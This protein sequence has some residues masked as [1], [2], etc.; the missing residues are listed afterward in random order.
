MPVL[1]RTLATLPALALL[2]LPRAAAAQTEPSV[3]VRTWAPSMAPEAG[4]VLEPTASPGS[5][6]WNTSAWVSY[7]QDPVVLRSSPGNAVASRPLEHQLGLDLVAGV[8]L[9][10]RA[11]IGVDVPVLLLQDGT[12]G[13]A[14]NI[15]S[16]GRVPGSGLGDVAILGKGTL[17]RNDPHGVPVGFGLAALGAVTLPT[18][19]RA[20]F[21]G[22]GSATVALRL[23]AEYALGPAAVR[24]SLG[25][26]LRTAQQ[27]W[28][29]ASL[30]GVTF[31]DEIPWSIGATLRP[32]GVLPRLD[33][34]DR[35]SWEIACH[36][37][38]PATP[39]TV[40]Q[41]GAASLSPALLAASDRITFGHYGD[42]FVLVGADFGLDHAV[43]VP[44]FRGVVSAGWAPRAHDRDHDGIPDDH[45]ECPDL[46]EDRDGIQDEDGCPEDDAD[47]DGVLD[48]QDACPLVPGV[49]WNDP[50]KNG[51]PAP[52]TDGDGV[53][54]P[55][56]A[57]PAVKGV[58]SDDPKKNGCPA[59]KQD[60]DHDGIPDDAD[61]CP[62]EPEDMD[63]FE[64]FDGC[65]DLDDD[66]DGIPDKVDACPRER[67]EPS[68]DPTRNGCPSA[69]RD[70]DTY[71][72]EVDACPDQP[73]TFNGV[74][75]EDGCPD[76]GGRP[77]VVVNLEKGV[78]VVR[79]AQPIAFVGRKDTLAIDRRS[80]T[81]L[82]ALAQELNRRPD[83]TLAV[84][85]RPGP[86]TPEEAQRA[87]LER[88][89]LVANRI[90][91]YAHRPAAAEAVGW[92][93]VKQQPGA[94]SGLGFA[95][96]VPGKPTAPA[97][98]PATPPAE[99]K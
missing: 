5:W 65:P 94:A 31:G 45:D 68:T 75:D 41:A 84:G 3:D 56:D 85:A 59:E 10:E 64:D 40:G 49:W 98:L 72:N 44:G 12:S 70:G 39:I 27:T 15:V 61:K 58:Q 55:L 76:E 14:S 7:A 6:E 82:R 74:K 35:Q 81:T 32:K 95:V 26:E 17:L 46:P 57:C 34:G 91:A 78:I 71:D 93:A 16:G 89:M 24:A 38:V 88:A 22:D 48:T 90:G 30:G 62:D 43:G 36:G 80:A 97:P 9:G 42:A 37:W 8:G 83:W 51:C 92:D 77:L 1:R 23:L 29:D 21:A 20:S 54:D 25:Y 11:A 86:G 28:P 4:L 47:S 53:P 99:K 67:G 50:K 79:L 69:D 2:A 33:S 19:D 13:L 60:R 63:G 18:G 87:A 96:L 73:E 52:D 66:G